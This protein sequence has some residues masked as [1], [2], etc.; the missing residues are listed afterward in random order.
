MLCHDGW[1]ATVPLHGPPGISLRSSSRWLPFPAILT[2]VQGSGARRSSCC[3]ATSF[4]SRPRPSSRRCCC[5]CDLTAGSGF[6]SALRYSPQKPLEDLQSHQHGETVEN[7]YSQSNINSLTVVV[8]TVTLTRIF[9]L[10]FFYSVRHSWKSRAYCW[11]LVS[12]IRGDL[13][14]VGIQILSVRHL[15]HSFLFGIS[16]C[17]SFY[18]CSGCFNVVRE[19]L[20]SISFW[21]LFYTKKIYR[22]QY[23]WMYS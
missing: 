18:F 1:P 10:L 12:P 20:S 23:C 14:R 15:C 19:I 22:M 11:R 3:H 5:C 13:C 9:F 2:H 21:N 4:K 8:R 16:C 6:P 7:F 17:I